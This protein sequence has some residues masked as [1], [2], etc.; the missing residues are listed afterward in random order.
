LQI[1]ETLFVAVCQ[2]IAAPIVGRLLG[3]V[4]PRLMIGFGFPGFAYGV[5]LPTT[6][7][8][9]WDFDQSLIPQ[10]FR[11]A[12][13]ASGLFNVARNLAGAAGL[14]VINSVLDKRLD[15]HLARL[16]E[17]LRWGNAAAEELLA[18]LATLRPGSAADAA[19]SATRQL[20]SL[21]RRDAS[22][23]ALA[24]AFL[25]MT[26]LFALTSGIAAL[27]RRP[28]VVAPPQTAH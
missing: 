10:I 17:K 9:D 15:L 8:R 7:T 12:E 4:D 13:N 20:A 27:M 21:A 2:F 3:K 11:A 18:T 25:G 5:Y 24:D 6:I 26:V 22:V 23:M 28:A 1:G 16:H 14:A 19:L